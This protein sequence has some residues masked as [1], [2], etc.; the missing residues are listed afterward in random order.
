[1]RNSGERSGREV[2]Q[3]YLAPE[4]ADPARPARWLAGFAGVEA[5]P[6]ESVEVTV[7]LPRRAFEIWDENAGAWAHQPGAYE[8]EAGRSVAD[9]RVSARAKV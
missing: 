4:Q 1:V 9:R 3:I 8:V 7:P 5:A 6:G 2:V